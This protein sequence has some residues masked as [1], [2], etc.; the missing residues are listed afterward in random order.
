VHLNHGH[1]VLRQEEY[2]ANKAAAGKKRKATN[3][4]A[5][6][7]AYKRRAKANAVSFVP[8]SQV[9]PVADVPTT[10][11][12]TNAVAKTQFSLNTLFG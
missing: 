11:S 7:R 8:V 1:V 12:S 10:S 2:R 3:P 9:H 6:K 4:G 5:P